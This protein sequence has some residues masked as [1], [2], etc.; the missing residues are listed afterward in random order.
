MWVAEGFAIKKDSVTAEE[1]AEFNLLELIGRY[2][3]E[4]VERD[5]LSRVTTCKMH[6]IVRVFALDIAKEE[7]FGS[8]NNQ[9]E[10][11]LL[12]REV[13]RLSACGWESDGSRTAGTGVEF[14]RL[15]TVMSIAS[16]TSMI[17]SILSGSKYLTV[18]ELQDTAISQVPATIGN[19]FN[20]RYIGLRRTKVQTLPDSIENL[21]NLE[22]LD[23]KQTRIEKLPPGIVKVE[24]L[25]HLFADSFADE[26]QTKFRCFVGVEVP[27]MIS[28]FQDLQTLETVCASIELPLQLMRMNKLQNVWIDN[29]NASNCELLFKALSCMPQLSSVLLSA[30]DENE[31]LSFQA[32]RPISTRLH[33]LIIRGG[34]AHGTLKCPIFQGHGRYLRYLALSW[35]NL[36]KED[37]LQLLASHVPALTFLSLNR[38][39]SAAILV[40]SAGCFPELKTLVLEY[41]PNVKQL[42]IEKDAIPRIDEIYILSLHELNMEPHADWIVDKMHN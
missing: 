1:V 14:P 25:R 36:G 12:D 15:R 2:M 35:C 9:G 22:T 16:S 11:M 39:S 3:L 32:L 4:V 13:R 31:T 28:N 20:L 27:K 38:V 29:I 8:A 6:D 26:N 30:S 5:E 7:M 17:P 42:V 24:K 37:P 40:L 19:L 41:M 18:L 23:I 33:R 21:S 10:M 34:W